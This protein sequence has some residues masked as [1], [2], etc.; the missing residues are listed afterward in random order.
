MANG[1]TLVRTMPF[2]A[3]TSVLRQLLPKDLKQRL[4]GTPSGGELLFADSAGSLDW[5]LNPRLRPAS[6]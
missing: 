1:E 2:A 4:R 3:D 5:H 6:A